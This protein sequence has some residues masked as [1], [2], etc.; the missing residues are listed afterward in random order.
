MLNVC[1]RVTLG[2]II[3][4]AA[5]MGVEAATATVPDSL[6]ARA[7]AHVISST[8]VNRD[9][10]MF[11]FLPPSYG[12]DE[13]RSYPVVYHLHHN[14]GDHYSFF[15]WLRIKGPKDPEPGSVIQKYQ[16]ENGCTI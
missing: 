14:G 8:I 6:P 13:D 3:S 15:N 10:P 5:V 1:I 4:V 16:G 7:E 12:E 2:W 11:V 9:V